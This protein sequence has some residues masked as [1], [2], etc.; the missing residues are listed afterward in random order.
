M[1]RPP[2]RWPTTYKSTLSTWA[3]NTTVGEDLELF[4]SK[5][6]KATFFKRKESEFFLSFFLWFLNVLVNYKAIPRTAPR[7]SVWH[8]LRAATHETELGDHD[9]CLSRGR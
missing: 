6:K 5:F 2:R 3:T 8:F 7:Q 4:R 9:F 1:S